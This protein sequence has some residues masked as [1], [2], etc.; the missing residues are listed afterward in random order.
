MFILC[1]FVVSHASCWWAHQWNTCLAN[2]SNNF[3]MITPWKRRRSM[4]IHRIILNAIAFTLIRINMGNVH[5]LYLIVRM[6]INQNYTGKTRWYGISLKINFSYGF[7]ILNGDPIFEPRSW[8][9][10]IQYYTSIENMKRMCGFFYVFVGIV[11]PHFCYIIFLYNLQFFV[12]K[13]FFCGNVN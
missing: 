1:D 11:K 2:I 6:L 4:A 10:I 8:Y 12:A 13:L 5:N 7:V 3:I 9:L